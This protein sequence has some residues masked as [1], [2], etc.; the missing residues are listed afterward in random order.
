MRVRRALR[1]SE[2]V[3]NAYAVE[4]GTHSTTGY[5]TGTGSSRTHEHLSTA[6]ASLYLMRNSALEHRNLNEVLLSCLNTL[7]DSSG[8]FAGLTQTVANYALAVTNNDD[9]SECE[10]TTTLGNLSYTVDSHETVLQINVI[11][12]FYF[13][14]CHNRLEFETAITS[15]VSKLLNTS[16]IEIT[17][18]V[19]NHCR[20]TCCDSVSGYELANLSSLLLLRHLLESER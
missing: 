1:L 3:L 14:H 15:C 12:I 16:V 5:K 2:D 4:N 9:S 18:T 6:E 10:C 7:S 8:N 20:N 19:E 11:I 13:I 17:V